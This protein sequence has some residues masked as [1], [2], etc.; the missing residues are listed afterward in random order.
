VLENGGIL[1]GFLFFES[2][3]DRE[4]RV[5]FQADFDAGDGQQK[6]ASIEIPFRVE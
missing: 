3:L 1:T 5:T 4:D 2:P 6:V